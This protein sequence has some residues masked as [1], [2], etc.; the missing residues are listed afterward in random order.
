M[1]TIAEHFKLVNEST[2]QGNYN[3]G[4][5]VDPSRRRLDEKQQ[6]AKMKKIGYNSSNFIA[7]QTSPQSNYGRLK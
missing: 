3:T 5:A 2:L 6:F 7:E 1:T 4:Q